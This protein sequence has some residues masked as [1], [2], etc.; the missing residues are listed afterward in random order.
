MLEGRA[1]EAVSLADE[2]LQRAE[3]QA[4]LFH[5]VATLNRIR[6]GALMQQRRLEEAELA[7]DESVREARATNGDHALALAL[8]GLVAL[9]QLRGEPTD[10]L[11][12]ERDAIFERLGILAAPA[13]PVGTAIAVAG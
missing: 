9:K 1:G 3:S 4:G 11:A 7:L 13:V 12:A 2:T 10:S 5:L 6:G 8:D